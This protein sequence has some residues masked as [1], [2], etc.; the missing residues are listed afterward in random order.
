MDSGGSAGLRYFTGGDDVDHREYQRWKSWA[1]NKMRVMD[2]LPKN[3]RGSFVWTLLQGRALEIV[4]HLKPS[5]YQC[6]GGDDAIFELLDQRWPQRERSDEMGEHIA[7]VFG[8]KARDGESVRQW[9]GRAR[10]CFDKCK[11]KTGVDFPEEARGW[12]L[13]M[14]SGMNEEQRAVVLARTQGDLKF[15]SMA[16][17]MRS[18]FP[19]FVVA[20]RKSTAAH[21]I[22][23]TLAADPSVAEEADLPEVPAFQDVELFLAEHG[24]DAVEPAEEC[25]DEA[26]VADILAVSWKEKR[27]E[28]NRL[29]QSR[30][31]HKEADSRR[32]F[33][34]EVEELKKRTRCHKCKRVGHWARECRSKGPAASGSGASST[35]HA[36]GCV[37]AVDPSVETHFVC[38]AGLWNG[39]QSMLDKLRQ[40]CLQQ[41]PVVSIL[42]VS[43]PG[44]AVLDSGCGKTIVGEKTLQ[45]FR[46]LWDE[47]GVPQPT[48][49]AE[50]NHFCY[51]NGASEL[52]SQVVEMPVCLAQ[53]PGVIRAAVVRGDAPLL[54][55]R[56]ALKKLGA[57]MDFTNDELKL[58][59]GA[60]RMPMM[61]NSAGQYMV[62]VTQFDNPVSAVASKPDASV[63]LAVSDEPTASEPVPQSNTTPVA[64]IG[65]KGKSKDYWVIDHEHHR[66]IRKHV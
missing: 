32:A 26:D 29:K 17:S 42:L 62:A 20:K 53:R 14:C 59:N 27:Q 60:H 58:F 61:L 8:M 56:P 10:E 48:P 35:A 5:D 55:S 28:L 43:S 31:F 7:A 22:E 13:L 64:V 34:I 15:D 2:K 38:T 3:A 63:V 1:L 16:T 33:R 24:S 40:R 19:D 57:E 50:E 23:P 54:L 30:Q 21:V 66:L 41:S 36:A 11:R 4:E 12:I 45:S 44:F 18:C 46:R 49:I 52:S 25:Y 6:D 39:P 37:Q 65:K 47:A 9:C 51:G